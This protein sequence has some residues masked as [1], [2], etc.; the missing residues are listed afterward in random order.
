MNEFPCQHS[1]LYIK[2]VVYCL[3]Q[4]LEYIFLRFSSMLCLD[5]WRL[6]ET[7][8]LETLSALYHDNDACS[9]NTNNIKS[10]RL[11]E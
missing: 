2:S 3:F 11:E 9:G 4:D 5:I 10:N 8:V 1:S 6:I 7:S